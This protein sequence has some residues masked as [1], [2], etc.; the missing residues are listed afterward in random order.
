[1]RK[2][3]EDLAVVCYIN[4]TAELKTAADVCVT[5]SN[6]VKI[7][8]ALPQKNIFFIPDGN[9]AAYV[10]EQVP[11]KNIIPNDGFCPVHAAITPE[12]IR[13]ARREHPDAEFLVPVSYTHLF[14]HFFYHIPKDLLIFPG[15]T[16]HQTCI[17]I[18]NIF[19]HLLMTA[20]SLLCQYQ[21]F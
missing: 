15:N 13:K 18:L 6:A 16:V 12:L 9:L 2:T 7:V 5:S 17:Q 8:K 21:T 3:Y 4:S 20:F 14:F 1:M 11:E 10:A 19:Y